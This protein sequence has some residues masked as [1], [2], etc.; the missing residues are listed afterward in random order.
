MS[1]ATTD[2]FDEIFSTSL[3]NYKKTLADNIFD[4]FP[5]FEVMNKAGGDLGEG[6][7]G[8]LV[9]EDNANDIIVPIMHGKN[10]TVKSYSGYDIIDTTPATGLGNAKYT[11]K[12]VAGTV[13]I[14]RFSE[15]QNAGKTQIIKLFDAKM[16]QLEQSFQDA[17]SVMLYSDGTGNSGK[18]LSGLQLIVADTPTSGTVGGIDRSSHTFWRNYTDDGANSAAAFD[19]LIADMRTMYLNLCLKKQAPNFGVTSLAVYSGYESKLLATIN[20]NVG[21][22]NLMR[23]ADY[24]FENY[25]FHNVTLTF[26]NDCGSDKMYFL[27]TKY[28]KLHVD[29]ETYFVN[30][31]FQRPY[32]QDARTAQVLLYGELCCSNC[33]MQGVLEDIT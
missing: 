23:N 13:T 8:G 18:D 27:N 6:E 26:D 7:R 20:Y 14:D 17:I 22:N 25:K 5:F 16:Q 30:M 33:R 31:P 19:A 28:L 3:Q 15:R 11:M 9:F 1:G 24:G 32:N 2:R 12:Q 10:T 21:M 4:A 29:K